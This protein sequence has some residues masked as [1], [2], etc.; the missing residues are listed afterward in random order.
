M[1]EKLFLS[2]RMPMPMRF[3]VIASE[4]IVYNPLE[5]RTNKM[6]CLAAG[7]PSLRLVWSGVRSVRVHHH[8]HSIII[9]FNLIPYWLGHYVWHLITVQSTHRHRAELQNLLFVFLD[10]SVDRHT[11]ARPKHCRHLY[12]SLVRWY[13]AQAHIEFPYTRMSP[14]KEDNK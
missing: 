4:R 2:R 8:H 14:K 7:S 1:R 13:V 11:F 5:Q 6:Q 10:I 3:V 12:R 9:K